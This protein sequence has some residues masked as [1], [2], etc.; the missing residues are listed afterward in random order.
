MKCACGSYLELK[1]GKFGTYFSCIKCG[2][3][4]LN[5]V[6]EINK[7]CNYAKNPKPAPEKTA[8]KTAEKKPKEITIRSDDPFYF[9]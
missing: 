3:M 5:K 7:Q 9:D 8:G 2:N 1:N 6:L 4:N